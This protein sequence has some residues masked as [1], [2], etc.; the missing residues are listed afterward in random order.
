MKRL[1]ILGKA[2]NLADKS[3]EDIEEMLGHCSVCG[4]YH[5]RPD[6]HAG[7]MALGE[8]IV[9]SIRDTE[10]RPPVI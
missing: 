8:A 10:A 9:K 2:F 5:I 1:V 7:A 6:T 4:G 3:F